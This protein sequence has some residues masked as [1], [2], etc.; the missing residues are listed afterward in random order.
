MS[1]APQIHYDLTRFQSNQEFPPF[2]RIATSRPA[3]PAAQPGARRLRPS[4]PAHRQTHDASQY[5]RYAFR[6]GAHPT[7]PAHSS[8]VRPHSM[9]A[10]AASRHP[11]RIHVAA[12]AHQCFVRLHRMWLLSVV[13]HVMY[14]YN[15]GRLSEPARGFSVLAIGGV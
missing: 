11:P 3:P 12:A 14:Y 4:T 15:V 8:S 9:P 7:P 5:P 13:P 10:L 1:L 2:S 6:R